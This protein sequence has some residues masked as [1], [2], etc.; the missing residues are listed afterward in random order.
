MKG[1]PSVRT[2]G[3]LMRISCGTVN[4]ANAKVC[5]R[6]SHQ[7]V[8][9]SWGRNVVSSSALW[10]CRCADGCMLPWVICFL[11]AEGLFSLSLFKKQMLPQIVWRGVNWGWREVHCSCSFSHS[12]EDTSFD[13]QTYRLGHYKRVPW[14]LHDY[15]FLPWSVDRTPGCLQSM[16][17]SK[18]NGMPF[19]AKVLS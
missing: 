8:Q 11:E 14:S 16:E 2:A 4:N 12:F 1:F 19:P 5:F 15:P 7:N 10:R 13:L 6:L 18:Y 17:Y 9:Q 3:Q